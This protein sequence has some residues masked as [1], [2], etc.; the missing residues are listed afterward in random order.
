LCR[1]WGLHSAAINAEL[2]MIEINLLSDRGPKGPPLISQATGWHGSRWWSQLDAGAVFILA[3]CLLLILR[4]AVHQATAPAALDRE[5]RNLR[6]AESDLADIARHQSF[7]ERLRLE[8]DTLI[9]KIDQLEQ[10]AEDRGQWAMLWFMVA[11]SLPP[12]M[13][14]RSFEQLSPPP[15]LRIRLHGASLDDGSISVFVEQL[16]LIEGIR[17]VR[18]LDV[19][20]SDIFAGVHHFQLEVAG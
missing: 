13:A 11:Q 2:A 15:A 8:R 18:L 3:L 1:L 19:E 7:E 20:A 4:I 16:H 14:L 10:V 9:Q 6:E 17:E 12:G 5:T